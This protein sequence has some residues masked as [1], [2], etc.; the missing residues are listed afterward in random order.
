MDV[1]WQSDFARDTKFNV[2]IYAFDED[3][4]PTNVFPMEE[5]YNFCVL[6][7]LSDK[8]DHKIHITQHQTQNL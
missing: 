8:S 5:I 4:F 2:K 1:K 7:S 6:C 3:D